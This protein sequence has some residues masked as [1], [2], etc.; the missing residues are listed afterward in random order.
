[1][2]KISFEI[3]TRGD[4]CKAQLW[5]FASFAR[6]K[7]QRREA[8]SRQMGVTPRK[9]A[10]GPAVWLG[11]RVRIHT[12]SIALSLS[13][14]LGAASASAD[15]SSTSTEQAYDKGAIEGTRN[16]AFGGADVAL[17]SSTSAVYDNPANLAASRVYHFEG[18]IGLSPEANRQTYGGGIAD[19]STNQLAA[20][21]AGADAA[22]G[23]A[24][25]I[26]GTWSTM[27][28][29]GINRQWTDL[30]VGLAYPVLPNLFVGLTGRYLQ[31][32][33]VTGVGPFGADLLSSG[34]PDQGLASIFTFN[35]GVTY[36]P[37]KAL[38]LA[39]LGQN[40]TYPN[41]PIAPTTLTAGI[42]LDLHVFSL[43][44]DEMT[45]FTTYET[46]TERLMVGTEVFLFDRLALRL[47]Y[48]FDAGDRVHSVSG[49]L[50]WIDKHFSVEASVRQD[51]I[52][53]HPNTFVV[54]G[55]RYFYDYNAAGQDPAMTAD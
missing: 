24:G 7:R 29:D 5:E 31:V 30:R 53:D 33:Q 11:R 10:A 49:G 32:N 43:E 8:F 3:L 4:I 23:L 54:F 17:G 50:G 20:R 25:G 45:D 2:Q 12:A 36:R 22:N 34:T 37:I 26:A 14:V 9:L 55:F 42:G 38:S 19:S 16:V 48:R 41:H 28:P 44:F 18:I 40:L 51:A 21:P 13:V 39:I 52:A 47:G 35:A 27:D 6:V 1:M 46:P 15:P